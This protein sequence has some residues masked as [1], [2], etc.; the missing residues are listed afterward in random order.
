MIDEQSRK[1][2]SLSIV[3]LLLGCLCERVH[4]DAGVVVDQLEADA[5]FSVT[6]KAQTPDLDSQ[7]GWEVGEAGEG[8]EGIAKLNE[9]LLGEVG[10]VGEEGEEVEGLS[11]FVVGYDSGRHDGGRYDGGH[12]DGRH[13][14]EN[15]NCLAHC[16]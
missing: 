13:E 12:S 14:D 11:G 5:D 15:S 2:L 10:E 9:E 4:R 3:T 7:F 16:Q 6:R 8:V 1:E